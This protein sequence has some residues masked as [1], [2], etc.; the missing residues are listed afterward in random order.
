MHEP[1]TLTWRDEVG[2]LENIVAALLV[3]GSDTPVAESKGT[4]AGL[5][6]HDASR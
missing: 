1:G 4:R 5:F 2:T 6:E 3:F